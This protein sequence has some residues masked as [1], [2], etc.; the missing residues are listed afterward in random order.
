MGKAVPLPGIQPA[1]L[2]WARESAHLSLEEVAERFGKP[3][4]EI[5]AWE[6]GA[7]APSYAA[8][9]TRL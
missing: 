4:D 8:R 6:S 2:K 5:S 3:V 9:K 7:A 1:L